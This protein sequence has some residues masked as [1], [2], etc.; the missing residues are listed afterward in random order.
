MSDVRSIR[1][2][3]VFG[4]VVLLTGTTLPASGA[5]SDE[6]DQP[7]ISNFHSTT[8][9][10]GVVFS[11]TTTGCPEGTEIVLS[12]PGPIEGTKTQVGPGG[13]FSVFVPV[14]GGTS[15]NVGAIAVTSG[16]QTSSWAITYLFM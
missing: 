3:L 2:A 8:V 4:L 1:V 15:G 14:E 7:V 10:G 5:A 13:N 6:R 12:G 9:Q 16:G 11:G